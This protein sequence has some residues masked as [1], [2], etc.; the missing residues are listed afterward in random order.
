MNVLDASSLLALINNEPG[1]DEVVSKLDSALLSSVSLS[2]ILQKSAV[3]GI[4]PSTVRSLIESLGVQIVDFDAEMATET[5]ELW[6]L[7]KAHGVSLA[8]RSCL[9]L[10]HTTGGI[11]VTADRAWADL[12]IPGVAVYVITR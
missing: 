9:A 11:A 5:A 8:D 2:E 12:D 6:P 10:A 1:A 4:D 3:R 7:T